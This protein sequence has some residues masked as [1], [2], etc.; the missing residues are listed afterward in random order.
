MRVKIVVINGQNRK[1][2]TWNIRKLLVDSIQGEKEVSEFF[3]P[4]DLNGFCKGCY[5]CTG[6]E[7]G[8]RCCKKER[9]DTKRYA[10]ACC[11][12]FNNKATTRTI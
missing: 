7:L 12:A 9:K 2:S 8:R 3:L 6:N 10:K 11:K 4:E 5:Q 1:G